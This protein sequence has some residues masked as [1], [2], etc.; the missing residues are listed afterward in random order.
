MGPCRPRCDIDF[1]LQ[2]WL[3]PGDSS[4]AVGSPALL[5]KIV[6]IS[7]PGLI[8][9]SLEANATSRRVAD[10]FQSSLDGSSRVAR[11]I[12]TPPVNRTVEES[13]IAW[14]VVLGV[15]HLD[16]GQETRPMAHVE[17]P[18]AHDVTRR[19]HLAGIDVGFWQVAT[20]QKLGDLE[21]IDLVVLGLA[22]VD[23]LHVEGMPEDEADTLRGAEVGEPVPAEHAFHG[24]GEVFAIGLEQS[25]E[26][27]WLGGYVAVD[28]GFALTIDDADVHGSGV[29]VDS[30]VV[31][32]LLVVESHARPPFAL[33]NDYPPA[34]RVGALGRG[35]SNRVQSLL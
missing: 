21:R 12:G 30:A 14:E 20:A 13:C 18:A 35:A 10:V 2:D 25:K 6:A 29:Q 8:V 24:D 19:S 11:C 23:G 5:L 32:V 4:Y 31:P 9:K 27:C 3:H 17:K 7:P 26:R 33:V 15:G 1:G 16:V 28:Q 22:A 34:Y